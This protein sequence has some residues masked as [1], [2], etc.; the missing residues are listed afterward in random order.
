MR[1]SRTPTTSPNESPPDVERFWCQIAQAE[2]AIQIEAMTLLLRKREVHHFRTIEHHAGVS[3]VRLLW[4]QVGQ[5]VLAAIVDDHRQ[6]N[7]CDHDVGYV[8]G[9]DA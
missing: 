7:R 2:M 9:L 1:R 8:E 5:A 4:A 6:S 3:A